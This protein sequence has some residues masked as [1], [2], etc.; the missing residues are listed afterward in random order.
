[1]IN[2]MK[3]YGCDC[4]GHNCDEFWSDQETGSIA[5][6]HEETIKYQAQED[7]WHFADDGK[8]YCPD[9]HSVDDSDMIS[10]NDG[11]ITWPNQSS[12]PPPSGQE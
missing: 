11:S 6:L 1:M 12:Q 5:H 8:T 7:D 9:C 3:M 4:D 10:V 2:E